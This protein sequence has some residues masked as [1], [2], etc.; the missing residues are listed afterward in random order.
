MGP[1]F[2]IFSD[3]SK[4]VSSVVADETWKSGSVFDS[5]CMALYTHLGFIYILIDVVSSGFPLHL[6]SHFGVRQSPEVL[7][8]DPVKRRASPVTLR[9]DAFSAK[10][11]PIKS[12]MSTTP[13]DLNCNY[14]SERDAK[15]KVEF[16]MENEDFES[17][18]DSLPIG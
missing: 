17:D 16:V 9:D 14:K 11:S 7:S 18:A 4:F 8:T 10:S 13:M 6:D 2:D 3:P 1:S 5:P 12:T 15:S